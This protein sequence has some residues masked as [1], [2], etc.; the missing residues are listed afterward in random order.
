[1]SYDLPPRYRLG[2]RTPMRVATLLHVC[3]A[4]G[5][6]GA[7]FLAF[8]TLSGVDWADHLTVEVTLAWLAFAVSMLLFG[9]GALLQW[10][11]SYYEATAEARRLTG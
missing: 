7:A 10:C 1:M 5:L 3:G 2:V 4:L 6:C 11:A 9:L 8:A